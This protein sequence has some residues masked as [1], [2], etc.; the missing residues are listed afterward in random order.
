[1]QERDRYMADEGM[2][3]EGG[4]VRWAMRNGSGGR[5]EIKPREEE[6]RS[7]KSGKRERC[8]GKG[9]GRRAATYLSPRA[10]RS[11]VQLEKSAHHRGPGALSL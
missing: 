8:G 10:K 3:V 9:R 4:S 6:C 1:M 5:L 11:K 2:G 7:V